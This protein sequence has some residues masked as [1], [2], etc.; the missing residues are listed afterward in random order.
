MK[1]LKKAVI[2][3][4]LTLFVITIVNIGSILTASAFADNTYRYSRGEKM[5][6]YTEFS[7]TTYL[8]ARLF[9]PQQ[10]IFKGTSKSGSLINRKADEIKHTDTV[11]ASVLGSFS[12]DTSGSASISISGKSASFTHI[13][14]NTQFIEINYTYTI[15]SWKIWSLH[16][17]S[18]AALRFGD[19]IIVVDSEGD[20]V[21]SSYKYWI[22][23]R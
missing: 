13:V 6:T 17:S 2:L 10:A 15:K 22:S 20:N 4:L 14:Q 21:S 3:L 9:I 11:S 1:T 8:Q 16:Q 18:T 7:G 23:F 19:R 12:V 5:D